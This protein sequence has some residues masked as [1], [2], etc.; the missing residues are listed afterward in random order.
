MTV[1][2]SLLSP[3]D[4]AG[5]PYYAGLNQI[6]HMAF[7]GAL[8]M[9]FGVWVAALIVAAIE[10]TQFYRMGATRKDCYQDTAFWAIGMVAVTHQG[11]PVIIVAFGGVW[12]LTTWLA[13]R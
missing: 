12:M 3:D 4:F 8:F 13:S 11:F 2:K 9:A 5:Q 1:L 10:L 6:G 7:G